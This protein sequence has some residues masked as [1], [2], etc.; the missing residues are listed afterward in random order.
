MTYNMTQLQNAE[1]VGQIVVYAS[2]ST[3]DLLFGLATVALF[4]I[5]VATLLRRSEFKEAL[6]VASFISFVLSFFLVQGQL[7]SVV[8]L[9]AY[10]ALMVM[11]I[12]Y[13][14]INKE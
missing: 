5:M 10:L 3:G 6:M 14:F 13:N 8:F 1:T 2:N 9:L 7:I 4:I 11:S 12:F